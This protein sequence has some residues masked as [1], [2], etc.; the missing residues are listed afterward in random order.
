MDDFVGCLQGVTRAL[1]AGGIAPGSITH[2]I[3]QLQTAFQ[4]EVQGLKF[5]LEKTI[6]GFNVRNI[7]VNR[8]IDVASTSIVDGIK[9]RIHTE[10]KTG[11]DI[12]SALDVT[13]TSA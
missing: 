8:I 11:A 10:I 12:R 9:T 7:E 4:H 6:S 3:A 1:E 13:L 2:T 5:E